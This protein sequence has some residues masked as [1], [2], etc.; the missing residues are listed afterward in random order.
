[1]AFPET[2]EERLERYLDKF[3]EGDAVARESANSGHSV[4][5]YFAAMHQ[6]RT[7]EMREA[8]KPIHE[9]AVLD[10]G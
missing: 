10:L 2:R 4:S 9:N 8:L 1:M 6:A 7:P 3:V 5:T